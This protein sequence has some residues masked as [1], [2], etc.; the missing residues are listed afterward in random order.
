M[1][2][3]AAEGL[4]QGVPAR[5]GGWAFISAGET[6]TPQGESKRNQGFQDTQSV[7]SLVFLLSLWSQ[8]AALQTLTHL[9]TSQNL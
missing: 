2:Q 6:R 7:C 8:P 3:T 9:T 5:E 1:S 4:L